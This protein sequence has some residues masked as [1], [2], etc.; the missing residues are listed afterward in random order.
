M[1]EQSWQASFQVLFSQP[2]FT[3]IAAFILGVPHIALEFKKQVVA[4][5][6][7]TPSSDLWFWQNA[8]CLQNRRVLSA[9]KRLSRVEAYAANKHGIMHGGSRCSMFR[10]GAYSSR[11]MSPSLKNVTGRSLSRS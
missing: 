8:V 7:K 3:A 9:L 11:S 10:N 2:I 5:K 6:P 4:I 1:T